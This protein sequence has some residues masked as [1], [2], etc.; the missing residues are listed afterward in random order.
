MKKLS[1]STCVLLLLATNIFAQNDECKYDKNEVDKFTNKKVIWTKWERLQPLISRDFAPDVRCTI[2]DT[3]KQLLVS[4]EGTDKIYEK[5]TNE[6]LENYI[7]VPIESKA[8]LLL[9]DN[10]PF[11]L[12]TAK[13]CR[14]SCTYQPV[15]TN[16]SNTS[17]NYYSLSWRLVIFYPLNTVAI[18]KLSS[19]GATEMR[20][21]FKPE[22]YQDYK[23]SKKKYS[24]IQN[25]VNCIK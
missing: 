21:Y 18:Q 15:Y 4:M 17:V 23:I 14:A 20:V 8:M 9:E 22:K 1:T 7:V 16:S 24:I 6:F 5:P 11:E 10:K 3:L 25:L 12:N 2:Q 19:Q 13:E